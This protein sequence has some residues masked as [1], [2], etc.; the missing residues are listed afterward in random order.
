MPT[1]NADQYLK[2]EPSRHPKV[3]RFR[4]RWNASARQVVRPCYYHG[5]YQL[6]FARHYSDICLLWGIVDP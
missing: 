3:I 4:G 1:W 5:E 2:F 6:L